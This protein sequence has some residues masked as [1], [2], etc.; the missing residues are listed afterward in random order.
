[1]KTAIAIAL[2]ALG[3][4]AYIGRTV[5]SLRTEAIATF[6]ALVSDRFANTPMARATIPATPKLLGSSVKTEAGNSLKVA[7][8]VVYMSPAHECGLNLCPFATA[9]CAAACLGHNS[10]LLVTSTSHNARLWK[11]AL[12]LGARKL[13]RALLVHETASHVARATHDGFIPALRIDG[14]TDTGEGTRVA[15]A[16]LNA[17]PTLRMYDYTKDV[18]RAV[19]H[20]QG[21]YHAHYHVTFSR[22]GENDDDVSRVLRAGGNVAAVFDVPARPRAD[23]SKVPFPPTH[24][25][26]PIIDGDVSDARF[27][28]SARGA[29]VGLRFKAAKNRPAAIASAGSFVVRF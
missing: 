18:R 21:E 2:N 16:L 20:A 27:L 4:S 24:D 9:G 17:F 15:D 26:T 5:K 25:G 6:G 1:M 8:R 7:T 28:D 19:A 23:G 22:S 12:Y 10:G 14:S 29:F 13:W 3:L 11:S